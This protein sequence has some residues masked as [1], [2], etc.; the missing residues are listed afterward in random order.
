LGT[1]IVTRQNGRICIIE[2]DNPPVNAMSNSVR[3][4]LLAAVVAAAKETSVDAIIITGSGK[5]FSGGADI[6][7]FGQVPQEPRLPDLI[8]AIERQQKPIIAALH[9]VAFGGGFEIALGSHFRVATRDLM[10]ALPE[11]KLGLIPGAGGTQRLPRL[12][13]LSKAARIIITGEPIGAKEAQALGILD[14]VFEDKLLENALAFARNLVSSKAAIRR[15]SQM[16]QALEKSRVSMEVFETEVAVLLKRSRGLDAPAACITSIRNTLTMTFAQ[17][18]V[19]ERE[20]FMA[21]RDGEQSKAQRHLFF[22]ER[23]AL[24]VSGIAAG[25]KGR[26]I[27]KVAVLGAGTMGGGIAMCF[28]SAGIPVTI[29]DPN[30]EALARGLAVVEANYRATAKRGGIGEAELARVLAALT[31]SSDFN[32]VAEADLIIEAVFEDMALKKKI[33]T[34]LDQIAK[35]GAILATNTSTLDVNEIASATMRPQD[36]L[37]MHFFSPANVMKL[38]E[39]VRGSASAPDVILTAME[40]GKRIAKVPVTVGV[41]Y[42][43]VGNRMLHARGGQVERLLLEGATPKD[44]DTAATAFG[45]LMGPCAVG[46]LA[47]LDVGWRI[48]KERGTKAIVADAICDLG[49]FG[50]KTGKGYFLYEPGSRAPIPDPEIDALIERLSAQNGIMRRAISPQEV[51]DRLILPLVNEGARILEEGI[52]ERSSDIDLIWINGYGFPV[53]RGGPMFYA[54]SRGLSEVVARL[55]DYAAITGDEKLRPAP[56]LQKLAREGR[57]FADLSTTKGG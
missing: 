47:G 19:R 33:F 8:D 30:P 3:A 34:D 25:T 35:P 7:E 51:Q 57:S 39:I 20:I 46:D 36:V 31:G 10:L 6:T 49:R 21:L 9:R 2:L 16:T 11:V 22:A 23:A 55:T 56:L 5:V 48:R 4:S 14:A 44:I 53:G 42:G 54:D 40:I 17:G 50:Q 28:A 43:F 41:C 27:G 24:K 1:G 37:G 13:G 18:L 52:A 15:V 29:I 26:L 32:S 12:V 45:F 38:L